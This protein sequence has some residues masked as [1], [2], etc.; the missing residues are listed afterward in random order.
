VKMAARRWLAMAT[1]IVAVAAWAPPALATPP[2]NDDF[3]NRE[4]LASSLPIEVTRSNVGATKEEGEPEVGAFAAGHSV[5]FEWEA[6]STGFVTI[7]A[8]EGEFDTVLGVFTGTAVNGLT[9]VAN[10]NESEGPHCPYSQSEYTFKATAGTPYEIGVDGNGFYLPEWTKPVTE[11]EFT[12]R[13]EATPTPP[14]DAFADAALL[15]GSVEEE[16]GA[17]FAFYY[18]SANGY[19]WNA[20]KEAG[21]PEHAGDPGGA[22]VWYSWTAPGSGIARIGLCCSGPEWL[23]AVYAGSAVDAL[24]PVEPTPDPPWGTGFAVSAGTTYRIAVDGR[25]DA[26]ATAPKTGSFTLTASMRLPP[27]PTEQTHTDPLP[28]SSPPQPG[29]PPDTT[30]VKRRLNPRKR[31]ARFTFSSSE[32]GSTFRC[33]LDKHSFVPC[34][35]PKAYKRLKPGRHAFRVAAVDA[36]GNVDPSPAV[37]HF[38]IPK[39]K[40]QGT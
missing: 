34:A 11:G 28:S 29:P 27:R 3:P 13:I 18:A 39:P 25:Y 23:I 7:G 26:E 17:A 40:S 14:N 36:A 20:T 22:S 12:L 4:V 10:G 8:C 32:P 35:S 6:T 37:V 30:I 9:K 16:E 24:T 33:K 31:T 1:A 15:S 21:E 19:N 2:A 38:K 5:W